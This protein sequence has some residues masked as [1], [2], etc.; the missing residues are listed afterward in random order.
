MDEIKLGLEQEIA[1]DLIKKFI[2]TSKETAFSL[3]GYAG[4]GKTTIIRWLID[5][6]ESE[7]I[8]YILAAPTHKAKSA[9]NYATNRTAFTL[10]QLLKLL[11]NME[12][13]NFDLRDLQ[14]N[15]DWN[16]LTD[17]PWDGIIICDESSMINDP[18]FNMLIQKCQ[19]MNTKIIFVGDPAQLKPVKSSEKSLVFNTRESYELKK[20]YRQSRES[21]LYSVL[22]TLREKSIIR[23]NT[24]LESEGSII[25]IN[26]ARELFRNVLPFFTKAINEQNI[27]EAKLYAYTNN[28]SK[29]LNRKMRSLLFFGD[30]PYYQGEIL[31]CYENF[32]YNST[33]Y[34]NSMDYIIDSKV[35]KTEK[36]IPHIGTLAGYNISLYDTSEKCSDTI[37]II[38]Q[39]T[40]PDILYSIA[41][42]IENTRLK[43]VDMKR[44]KDRNARFVWEKYFDI[45][46]SFTTPIDLI[47]D[48]RIVKKKTFDY[49]YA[50]TVHKSQGSSINNVAIDMKDISI[51]RDELELRQLQYV[52]V[53]R[54]KNNVYI[55]Q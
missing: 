26:D 50:S 40:R 27:F 42:L 43:A 30:E 45:I 31:T 1:V 2:S 16:K 36:Y 9:I 46:R 29:A 3:M 11:P 53:S 20:I 47:Y 14:F 6:L 7:N 21:A 55:L 32:V 54:V 8:Q 52:A 41:S 18:L 23:F 15:M 17:I 24:I 44:R 5:Y 12:I 28:R 37:F 51:C 48:N 22:P 35:I 4:T 25:C 10:H 13:I 19:D 38:D 34:W 33:S 49:G 39:E